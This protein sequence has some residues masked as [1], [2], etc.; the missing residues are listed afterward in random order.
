MISKHFIE[1]VSR[2]GMSALWLSDNILFGTDQLSTFH[3]IVRLVFMHGIIYKKSTKTSKRGW[4]SGIIFAC[5]A[6]GPGSIPG[7]R[8]PF[9]YFM[10]VHILAI[11]K[12]IVLF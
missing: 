5:H 1:M 12:S 8:K 2:I 10:L 9:A 7:P 3:V 11:L 6:K 4:L